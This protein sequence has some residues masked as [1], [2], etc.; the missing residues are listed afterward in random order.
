MAYKIK[1][2]IDKIAKENHID[3]VHIKQIYL[4]TYSNDT[5]VKCI[6]Q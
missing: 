5:D 6:Y 4:P 2:S 3:N 1:K